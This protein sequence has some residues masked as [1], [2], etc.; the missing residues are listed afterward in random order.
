MVCLL[1]STSKLMN[2][3]TSPS[4][5]GWYTF[6]YRIDFCITSDISNVANVTA[7]KFGQV[8]QC[9]GE[10]LSMLHQAGPIL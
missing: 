3:T 9:P 7:S 8:P 6:R 2:L 5:S 4:I 10:L 1:S